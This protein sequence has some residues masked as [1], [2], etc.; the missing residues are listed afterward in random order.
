MQGNCTNNRP[1]CQK[2]AGPDSCRAGNGS[3]PQEASALGV[4]VNPVLLRW[5]TLGRPLNL[6]E[7]QLLHPQKKMLIASALSWRPGESTIRVY[8]NKVSSLPGPP[9]R[10][11]HPRAGTVKSNVGL[12]Q[13]HMKERGRQ[14][15]R[16]HDSKIYYQPPNF[17][18]LP[19]SSP[20]RQQLSQPPFFSSLISLP[21]K[22]LP[23]YMP[24]TVNFPMTHGSQPWLPW[25]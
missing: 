25:M 8:G 20:R 23:K 7:C 17:T 3:H 5:V 24:R 1:K 18:H 6:S 12:C 15:Y 16:A 2:S 21:L 22:C 14:S 10:I 13:H 9:Y 19:G 4:G 11:I